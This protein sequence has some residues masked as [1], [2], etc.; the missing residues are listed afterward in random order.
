MII[1]FVLIGLN[2]CHFK[3]H[4]QCLPI[5]FA[6][7][8]WRHYYP[9]VLLNI[10]ALDKFTYLTSWITK[11]VL[12]KY[13][14]QVNFPFPRYWR[15]IFEESEIVTCDEIQYRNHSFDISQYYDMSAAQTGS[16]LRVLSSNGLWVTCP[17]LKRALG[18]VSSAQTGSGLHVL[19]SNGLWVT[20]PQL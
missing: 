8:V 4:C 2:D 9:T 20:C 15:S 5:L 6:K 1:E 17:Q 11:P 13:L 12:S 10:M 7:N 18:Y 16:G 3:S 14:H 19:S